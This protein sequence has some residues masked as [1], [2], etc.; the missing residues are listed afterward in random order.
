MVERYPQCPCRY[1]QDR[2]YA[3]TLMH[4]NVQVRA[5]E[6]HMRAHASTYPHTTRTHWQPRARRQMHGGHEHIWRRDDR[7]QIVTDR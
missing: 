3:C 6:D 5:K 2:S 1:V 4:A 7:E